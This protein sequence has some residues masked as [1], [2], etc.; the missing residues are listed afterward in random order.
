[1][2]GSTPIPLSLYVHVPW[3]LR[4]CPYCDFNSH[5]LITEALPETS[6]LNALI[7]D[8]EQ[9]LPAVWGRRVSSVFFGG[10][11]PSLL[12]PEGVDWLLGALRARLP[13]IPDA[14]ITLEA[15]PG[16]VDESRFAGFRAA[17]IN[18]LSLGIQSFNDDCLSRL[19]RIHNG[20]QAL[21]AFHNARAAGFTRINLDLMYGLPGQT[22]P[23][24]VADLL[25]AITLKPEHLSW[26][27]LTLEPHTPFYQ[28][29]P[30]LPEDDEL[31]AM[32]EQGMTLLAEAGYQRYE[33]SGYAQLGQRC[34]HNLNYWTF[35][36]Y[37]GIGAGAHGKVTDFQGIHRYGK[38]RHPQAYL[39]GVAQEQARSEEVRVVADD[40]P[41]EFMLNA[42]RLV[43]GVPANLYFERTGLGLAEQEERLTE[44]RRRG[45]LASSSDLIVPTEEGQRY[46]ND[47][48]EL[49]V[50]DKAN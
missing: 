13:I 27:Q 39:A 9:E 7:Q 36:D 18:R 50:P 10:G 14:E 34:C 25:Q 19:E 23:Q 4:K 29:P 22:K 20:Y 17:G 6:Y 2:I 38:L 30:V 49:F 1:M 43:E 42:L 16:T 37:L 24:A 5:A 44:A 33:I 26:Y 48:L 45:W 3:C 21:S 32:M 31:I 47:L 40:L 11:T 35:G 28:S 15:N 41:L 12:S 8:L 46:L